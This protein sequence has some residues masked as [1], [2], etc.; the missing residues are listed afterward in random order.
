MVDHTPK[1]RK[2][3]IKRLK[4][5]HLIYLFCFIFTLNY[6]IFSPSVFPQD[7]MLQFIEKKQIELKEREDALSKEEERLKAIRKDIDDRMEK[8]SKLLT[9]IEGVLKKLEQVHDD[10]IDRVV[11]TYEFMSPEEAA[12]Q[13]SALPETIAVK[14]ITR[15]KPKKAGSVM[16]YIEPKKA[17][18]LTE[19]MAKF[20]KN[21]PPE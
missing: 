5:K 14:I 13:L 8:Y 6:C 17:A 20:E 1:D 2:Y 12:A 7:D 18:L 3:N 11:K 10:K 16:A 15:M 9:Q 4:S 19:S 21:F